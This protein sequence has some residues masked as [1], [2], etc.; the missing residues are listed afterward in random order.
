MVTLCV[1]TRLAT[2]AYIESH[3]PLAGTGWNLRDLLDVKAMNR[4]VDEDEVL[5]IAAPIL[6]A[7]PVWNMDIAA[8]AEMMEEPG[9]RGPAPDLVD[10]TWNL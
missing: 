10:P 4:P 1:P 2:N 6:Y 9:T 3:R 7:G 8:V 5:L